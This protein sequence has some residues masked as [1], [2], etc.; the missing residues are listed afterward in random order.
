[1]ALL[2]RIG[3]G[4]STLLRIV[5]GFYKPSAGQVKMD[6]LEM[7]QIDPASL[8]SRIGWVGQQPMLFMGTLRE[9]LV[10]A[11]QWINDQQIIQVLQRLDLYRLVAG[12]PL[13]LDMPLSEAGGGL[14]GGQQQLLS[15]ARMML[16]E[17][18]FVFMD[19]PTS[20]MD[21]NTETLVIN[22]LRE[23]LPGRTVLVATHRPQLLD[24]VDSIGV[25]D[26]GRCLLQGPRQEVLDKLSRGL[27]RKK[28]AV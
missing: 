19:E 7:S 27:E 26:A 28:A 17:P 4:K 22:A 8:R 21:Q 2:G 14:S 15:V 1:M 5:A 18:M 3:S 20:N 12:H 6:G 23:W 25:M 10:L 13:G 24:L 11:D 9:N 16:R